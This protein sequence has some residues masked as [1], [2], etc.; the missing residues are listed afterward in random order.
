M[1]RSLFASVMSIMA[2]ITK[3]LKI[4]QPIR[5]IG[6]C[7][8]GERL[9]MMYKQSL[10]AFATTLTNPI[11][12]FKSLF[13]LLIHR[14]TV[15]SC[16]IR[17]LGARLPSQF[18][19]AFSP[20]GHLMLSGIVSPYRNHLTTYHTRYCPF[21]LG[22]LSSMKPNPFRATTITAKAGLTKTSRPN[23]EVFAAPLTDK[24]NRHPATSFDYYIT[25]GGKS[26][27]GCSPRI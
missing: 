4:F 15:A 9:L 12:T 6:I 3:N 26:Q 8:F 1:S 5:I 11:R 7:E 13:S 25:F 27:Y 10:S 16:R 21:A 24:F 18:S 19:I 2:S 17:M 22:H 23:P 20:T 14:I